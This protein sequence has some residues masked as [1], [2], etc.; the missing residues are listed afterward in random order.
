MG[1]EEAHGSKDGH[2]REMTVS[3]VR[4]RQQAS[5]RH[6]LL[7]SIPHQ[8]RQS[9]SRDRLLSICSVP[10]QLYSA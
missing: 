9:E 8:Q 5:A 1:I 10:V 7:S 6:V 4:T 2:E 3:I